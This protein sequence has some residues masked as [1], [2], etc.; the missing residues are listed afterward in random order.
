MTTIS[1]PG[2][3]TALEVDESGGFEIVALVGGSPQSSATT[4]SP[5]GEPVT[6]VTT[7]GSGNTNTDY[8]FK[9]DA[10]F[11]LGDVVEVYATTP[12][13][14]FIIADENGADLAQAGGN[15][16]VGGAVRLRK[17]LTGNP[18]V[19]TWGVVS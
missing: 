1:V 4:I 19:P 3:I 10:S 5:S 7:P 2:K 12:G 18:G 13:L 9:L 17:I 8:Y 15:G 14:G 6:I 16:Y 11:N